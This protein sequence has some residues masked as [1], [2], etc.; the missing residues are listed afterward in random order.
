MPAAP[1]SFGLAAASLALDA[2]PFNAHTGASHLHAHCPAAYAAARRGFPER[3]ATGRQGFHPPPRK[4]ALGR[5]EARGRFVSGW[6]PP[7]FENRA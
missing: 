5:L 7:A 4:P 1:T 6:L 3:C 2:P